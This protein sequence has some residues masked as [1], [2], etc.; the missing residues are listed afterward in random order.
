MYAHTH[1][2]MT[3]HIYLHTLSVY[4]VALSG[5]AKSLTFF[6]IGDDMINSW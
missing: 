5:I 2:H 1:I 3:M 6:F 4:M